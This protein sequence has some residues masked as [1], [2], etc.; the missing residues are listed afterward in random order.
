MSMVIHENEIVSSERLRA[1]ASHRVQTANHSH[2][3]RD[4]IETMQTRAELSARD[5]LS[6]TP[7]FFPA[8]NAYQ[9]LFRHR[10][11]L[12]WKALAELYRPFVFRD[13]LVFDIGANVG[14]YSELFLQMGARVVAVEPNQVCYPQLDRVAQNHRIHIERLACGASCGTADLHLAD[15]PGICT[16][17]PQWVE[18]TR[19]SDLYAGSRWI[20]VRNVPISTLD[21]L[22]AR[23]GQPSFIKIDVEGYEDDVLSGMT[24]HPRALSFEFHTSM[25]QVASSCLNRLDGSYIFNY[26]IADRARFE[27][28]RWV[29]A[30]DMERILQALPARPDFG[31]VYALCCSV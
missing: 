11:W 4:L 29:K 12:F 16:I 21:A 9:R 19:Q 7:L 24:F 20:G 14:L 3:L 28:A 5:A 13:A 18:I 1:Y 6:G 23:H 31:D 27:L 22:A 26:V 25:L 2:G 10:R 15:S 8:R 17:S 30:R